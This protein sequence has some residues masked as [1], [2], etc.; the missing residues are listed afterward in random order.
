MTS[1]K[2]DENLGA[3]LLLRARDA[4]LDAESVRSEGLGGIDD[5]ALYE[6]CNKEERALITLDLDF[7]NPLRFPPA[8]RP[9]TIVLRPHRPSPV[10]IA[11]LFES[12]LQ[13][14]QIDR[15]RGRI[16]IVEPGRVRIY[17]DWYSD[18]DE[19]V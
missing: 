12:A 14:L 11:E 1:I 16:W 6:H 17:H 10:E 3:H 8:G 9:G 4:G 18:E 19:D 15:V 2:L 13:R 5:D 7:S